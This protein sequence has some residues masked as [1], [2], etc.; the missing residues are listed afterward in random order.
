MKLMQND[1]GGNGS[2]YN[3]TLLF[4]CLLLTLSSVLYTGAKFVP[5]IHIFLVKDIILLHNLINFKYLIIPL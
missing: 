5:I 2:R 3:S 4:L 1:G